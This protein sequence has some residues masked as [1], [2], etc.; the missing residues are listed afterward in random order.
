M[1]TAIETTIAPKT[2]HLIPGALPRKKV[3][4][5]LMPW[6]ICE[7]ADWSHNLACCRPRPMAA[8]QDQVNRLRIIQEK[9][10]GQAISQIFQ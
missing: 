1:T 4:A 6:R 5:A 3:R 7:S 10:D 9:K 8:D 2:E